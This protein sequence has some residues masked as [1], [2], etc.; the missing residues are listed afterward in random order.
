MTQLKT[1][2]KNKSKL[3]KEIKLGPD[4]WSH[5][6]T[7]RL[8]HISFLLAIM[9]IIAMVVLNLT[10][11]LF[12][13]RAASITDSQTVTLTAYV[14]GISSGP[15]TPNPTPG[16]TIST[17]GSSSGPSEPS[18][19]PVPSPSTVPANTAQLTA[20]TLSIAPFTGQVS[21][22]E[23]VTVGKT[24]MNVPVFTTNRPRFMGSTNIP[25][26]HVT[27]TLVADTEI[28]GTSTADANGSFIWESAPLERSGLYTV[29][30]TVTN[31]S[32]PTRQ[33]SSSFDFISSFTP[34][35]TANSANPSAV[36]QFLPPAF[37]GQTLFDV[38]ATVATPDK[39]VQAGQQVQL[40]LE[41]LDLS[42]LNKQ[43][44]VPL[45][46]IVEDG[47]G[48]I[49]LQ[50]S[51]TVA[52]EGTKS[53]TKIFYT[54]ANTP[55]GQYLVLAEVPSQKSYAVGSDTFIIDPPTSAA[56]ATTSA[57][58]QSAGNGIP[59][60]TAQASIGLIIFFLF[61][62]YFEYHSIRAL[63]GSIRKVRDSDLKKDIM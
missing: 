53:F 20:A 26:A 44:D 55:P 24:T 2:Q 49:V 29:K 50:S 12:P 54:A 14:S 36:A 5:E 3:P 62:A 45:E 15:T 39:H 37:T 40:N 30:M 4:S 63:S 41:L 6:H 61:V 13:S 60:L 19:T 23:Q 42:G 38:Y 10:F 43:L 34:P 52:V 58:G 7:Q 25:Y 27:V 59:L 48:T 28:T 31:P 51:E 32:D 21:T 56:V 18:P 57:N 11:I 8:F 1:P 16:G 17:G 47:D 22:T 9:V 35:N 46:F 33:T